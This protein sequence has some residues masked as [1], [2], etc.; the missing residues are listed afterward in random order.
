MLSPQ[1][2]I[3]FFSFQL[4]WADTSTLKLL[5]SLI[6]M[7]GSTEH[8]A[9]SKCSLLFLGACRIDDGLTKEVIYSNLSEKLQPCECISLAGI[10]IESLKN[11]MSEVLCLPCRN[12]APL[13]KAIHQKTQG[14]PLFVIEVR[15]FF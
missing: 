2:F 9:A 6:S 14:I 3:M 1:S 12:I 4:Q 15:T 8:A 5:I 7:V 10:D 13:A 11:M